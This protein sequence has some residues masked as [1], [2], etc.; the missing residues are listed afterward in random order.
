[1]TFWV[2]VFLT[3]LF[4]IDLSRQHTS[5]GIF[6]SGQSK[7]QGEIFSIHDLT[8]KVEKAY[9]MPTPE[10]PSHE[11][12]IEL[13]DPSKKPLKTLGFVSDQV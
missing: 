6:S 5:K 1:M 3:F 2:S 4:L 12:F 11:R 9:D 10:F 13:N 7:L 8:K